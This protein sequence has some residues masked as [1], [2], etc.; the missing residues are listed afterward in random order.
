MKYTRPEEAK[1]KQR[2]A[3]P[4]RFINILAGP[5]QVGKTTIIRDLIPTASP[6][7]YY[8]SV[9]EEPEA[10]TLQFGK[11]SS[12]VSPPQKRMLNGCDTIVILG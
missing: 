2:L 12:P 10:S 9:D 4:V 3:E 11:T 5:R 6:H 1:L 7:G 8:I